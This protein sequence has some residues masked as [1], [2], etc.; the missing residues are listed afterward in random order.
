MKY[1]FE[2]LFNFTHF[3]AMINRSNVV[4]FSREDLEGVVKTTSDKIVNIS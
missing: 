4:R 3:Q 2:I 1:Q